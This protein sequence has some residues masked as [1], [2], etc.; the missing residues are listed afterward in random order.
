VLTSTGFNRVFKALGLS[1]VDF[2]DP[3]TR[4]TPAKIVGT[5]SMITVVL[6]AVLEASDMMGFS[7]AADLLSEFVYFGSQVILGLII[8][9]LGLYFSHL[10]H[11]LILEAAGGSGAILAHV[12]RIAIIVLAAA[13]GVRQMGIAEDIVNLAFALI[14]GAIALA[15]AIAFGFGARDIAARELESWLKRIREDERR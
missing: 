9:G 4:T 8:F 14:I 6:F 7:Y 5:L 10:A 2:S 13:M 15:L 12:A 11:R 1:K 3:E